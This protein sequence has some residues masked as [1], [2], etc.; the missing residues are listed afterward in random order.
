VF[1]LTMAALMIPGSKLTD[2]LGRKFCFIL[3]LVVY[4]TGAVVA[5]LAPSLAVLILGYSLLQGIGTALLIPPVYILAR[6]M[7]TDLTSRARAFG[8]ISAAGGIGAAAGP[9]IGGLI[10][11]T[12]SWRVSFIVQ[13][14]VVAGIIVL[15][16]RIVDVPSDKK[17]PRFDYLGAVLSA[18]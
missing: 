6:V 7:A 14:L 2:I 1:T 12:T 4:G 17:K 13:A 16:R 10:T 15:A 5:S 3:G 8:T 18:V 11:T 9:L